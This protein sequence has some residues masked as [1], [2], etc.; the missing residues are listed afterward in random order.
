MNRFVEADRSSNREN[1]LVAELRFIRELCEVVAS[2]TELRP[3]LDWVVQATTRMLSAD[4][5]TV[6]LRGPDS[7][8]SITKSFVSRKPEPGSWP[9]VVSMSVMGYLDKEGQPLATPDLLADPRFAGLKG[10]ECRVRALLAV[11]LRVESRTTGLLA[12]SMTQPGRTWTPDE[13]QLLSIVAG[14]SAGV[15]E[16]ARYRAEALER[17]RLE[18]ENRLMERELELAWEIQRGLIPA[19][20]LCAGPWQMVGRV[21]PARPV[22]GDYFDYCNLSAMRFGVAIADVAGKGVPAALLGSTVHA[23]L[24]AYCDGRR[25]LTEAIAEVNRRLIADATP[26]RFVTTFHAEADVRRGLLRFV[27]AGHNYPLVRRQDGSLEA[28]VEG[29]PPLGVLPDIAYAEGEVPFT[30]GDALLLYSDGVSEAR[31]VLKEEFGEER[32]RALWQGCAGLG[33]AEAVERLMARVAEF[34][35]AEPPSDDVTV[36][37]VAPGPGG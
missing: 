23:Y 16:R 25:S 21:A 31:N 1:R 3:I 34:R 13:E 10:V 7:D 18:A 15:I 33:A 30:P 6:R 19:A 22:G 14:N 28:L 29:G 37:V 11:P 2:S 4:E 32:V 26:G 5:V 17:Q 36:V 20:P 24:R 35:G 9:R 27:N 8:L 12:V